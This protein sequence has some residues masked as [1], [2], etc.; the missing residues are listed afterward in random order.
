MISKN[1][2]ASRIKYP[3]VNFIGNK[4]K[5]TDWI[6]DNTPSGVNTVLDLFSGGASVAYAYKRRGMSVI[7]NDIMRINYEIGRALIENDRETLTDSDVDLIFKGKPFRGFVYSNY[8]GKLFYPNECEQLDLY[9]ENIRHLSSEYKKSLALIL[10]RRSLIRKMPYSRFNIKWEKVEQL[11]DEEY[12]YAKYKRRRAYHNES[13]EHHFKSNIQQYNKAVFDNGQ[14]NVS[15]NMDA[16]DAIKELSADLV[17]I[18]PPYTGTMNNYYEFYSFLD[19]YIQG[20]V[21]PPFNNNF[22]NK[23]AS[24]ELFEKLFSSLGNFKYWMLSYNTSSF[25]SKDVLIDIISKH[26]KSVKVVEV[27]HTYKITGK[28]NKHKNSEYLFIAERS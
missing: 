26:A 5:I 14:E 11:R 24:I 6:C 15:V 16:F 4:E 9:R 8:A 20:E 17:Y 12:S 1:H 13:F 10:M 22:I 21:I 7:S 25:P 28:L 27:K 2:P 23:D 19:N 18:D 3:T